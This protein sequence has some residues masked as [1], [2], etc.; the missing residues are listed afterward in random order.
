M[1]ACMLSHFSRV[2]LFV[3]LWTI[4]HQTPLSRELSRQEYWSGLPLEWVVPPARDLLNPG[5]KYMSSAL[6]ADS[7]PLSHWGSPL[8]ITENTKEL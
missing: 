4:A 7:L 2:R 5:I 3:T 8:P 6:Q 1:R